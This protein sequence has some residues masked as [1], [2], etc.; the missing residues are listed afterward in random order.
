M[1]T[2]WNIGEEMAYID[3]IASR[4]EEDAYRAYVKWLKHI[5]GPLHA[6]IKWLREAREVRLM[7]LQADLSIPRGL[8]MLFQ[9]VEKKS[10][11]GRKRITK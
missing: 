4:A 9:D 6:C 1:I 10:H 11:S 3:E 7:F 2:K 8:A 5:P